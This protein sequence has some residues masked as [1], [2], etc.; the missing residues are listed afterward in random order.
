MLNQ[1]SERE[2]ATVLAALRYWQREG[3]HSSGHEIEIATNGGTLAA[4][5]EGE[6]DAL[7]ER[8]NTASRATPE[9]IAEARAIYAAGSGDDV[10]IDDDAAT[11]RGGDPGTWIAAWVWLPDAPP[12]ATDYTAMFWDDFG[13]DFA[14]DT[15]TRPG[16]IDEA[17]AEAVA[18][19]DQQIEES[20]GTDNGIGYAVAELY[21]GDNLIRRYERHK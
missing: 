17:E 16:G 2:L 9:Q 19:F 18:A 6:I 3:L 10:E 14:N 8:I 20:R 5:A 11:S 15:W 1:L 4:M 13:S 7:C 12:A 21:Q